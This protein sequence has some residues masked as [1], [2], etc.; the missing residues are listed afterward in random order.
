MAFKDIQSMVIKKNIYTILS[1]K[2]KRNKTKK[3]LNATSEFS[4]HNI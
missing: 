3:K 4:N 2:I 1:I